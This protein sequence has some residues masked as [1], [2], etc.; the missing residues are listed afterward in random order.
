LLF[1]PF[2]I[3]TLWEIHAPRRT[4]S[5]SKDVR[6]SNNLTLIV[7]NSLIL[8]FLFP[9][10]AI[11]IALVTQKKGWGLPNTY[12][13]SFW[14]SVVFAVIA[15]DFVIYLQ[16][17]MVHAIPVLWRLHQVHHAD[18][19]YDVT[20][21]TRFYT[22]EIILPILIKLAT[23]MALGPPLIAVVIFEVLLN[24]TAMFYHGNIYMPVK[25]DRILRLRC[26]DA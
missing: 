17:V 14:P 10:A 21:A 3:I 6:W 8:R 4:L 12:E 2:A 18:L 24:T 5:V 15:I 26:G 23:I 7:L 20:T 25:F 13:F 19:D 1:W 16:H 9:S 11:G 22:I